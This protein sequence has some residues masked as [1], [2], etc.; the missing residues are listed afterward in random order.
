MKRFISLLL[1]FSLAVCLCGCEKINLDD[2]YSAFMG[3]MY[4]SLFETQE[5]V[6][7][8]YEEY[9]VRN[10]Q[11]SCCYNS[12][13][14]RQK[15]IYSRI[16]AVSENMTEGFINLGENYS[17][18]VKDT[19]I[20]YKAFLND[21]AEIFWMPST[22]ILGV[23]QRG[24]KELLAIAFHYSDSKNSN[25]YPLS[26][27]QRDTARE[28]LN[29]ACDTLLKKVNKLSGEYEKE[30]YI[31]DFLCDKITYTE[32]GELV[33]TSYGAIVNGKA[34]CEGYSRAFKLLCNKAGIECE[35]IVGKAE[36]IGHMWNRVN[37]DKKLAYVDVTWNDRA[38]YKTY[39]YFNIT[40]EQLIKDHILAPV[41]TEL[42]SDEAVRKEAFNFT[43]K[44]CTFTGN[45]FFEKNNR[46]L[47]QDYYKTAADTINDIYSGS[48]G[49]AEFLFATE[50]TEKQFLKDPQAFIQEIQYNVSQAVITSYTN[51]RD[52]LI[53]FF[54]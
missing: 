26:K 48:E 45:S 38:D 12:L 23:S 11:Y 9:E 2:L 27:A 6:E 42:K 24:G 41:F 39:T 7:V 10:P 40:E 50:N 15:E 43:Y 46:L 18:G 34:L 20:A 36:D 54:E 4:P 22:Y 51:E 1:S 19:A 29:K 35:L 8:R 53:L 5:I 13:N 37:I 44:K 30:K 14:S 47:W 49:Y 21:N 33:H 3:E 32:T 31:N 17:D 16:Y 28:K 52:T 25:S